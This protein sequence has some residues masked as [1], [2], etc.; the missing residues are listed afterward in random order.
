MKDIE[1][2][3]ETMEWS[4]IVEAE[5]NVDM[6]DVDASFMDIEVDADMID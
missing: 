6:M 5:A 4:S 3:V 1:A 2:D